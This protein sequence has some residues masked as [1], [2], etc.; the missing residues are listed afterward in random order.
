MAVTASPRRP[1]SIVSTRVIS[2]Q[3][4]TTIVIAQINAGMKGLSTQRLVPI[5][6]VSATIVSTD[7]VRSKSW[8]GDAALPGVT[9]A[10]GS[11]GTDWE[12]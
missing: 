7:R 3:V 9:A 6:P 4:V 12:G 2:G 10:V 11:C 1:H 5:S 8:R